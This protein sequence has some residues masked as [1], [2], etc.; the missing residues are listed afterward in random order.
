[1]YNKHYMGENA[2]L[3]N[4]LIKRVKS[5]YVNETSVIPF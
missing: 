2:K 5:N 3:T 1:M 4:A